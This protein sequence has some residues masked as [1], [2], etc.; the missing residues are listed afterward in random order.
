MARSGDL[1]DRRGDLRL[2]FVRGG[3]LRDRL[4][5]GH[6]RERVVVRHPLHG[7]RACL[8]PVVSQLGYRVRLRLTGVGIGS[9]RIARTVQF[10][11]RR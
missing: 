11:L 1:R 3:D 5:L 6:R 9:K 10:L 8:R 7:L 4:H 2:R